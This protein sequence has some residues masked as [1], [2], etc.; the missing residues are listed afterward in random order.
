MVFKGLSVAKS[1]LRPE[2]APLTTN[3]NIVNMNQARNKVT[4]K[5]LTSGL[6]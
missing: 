3:L 2:S 6:S 5:C 4:C 1:C